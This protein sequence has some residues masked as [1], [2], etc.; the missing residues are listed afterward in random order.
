M[1]GVMRVLSVVFVIASTSAFAEDPLPTAKDLALRLRGY[2]SSIK[3]LRVRYRTRQL[4][5]KWITE[6]GVDTVVPGGP[7]REFLWLKDGR[8][9]FLGEFAGEGATPD[10]VRFIA[11]YDGKDGYRAVYFQTDAS[12]LR[13][14]IVEEG[15]PSSLSTPFARLLGWEFPIVTTTLLDLLGSKGS[16]P[17]SWKEVDG[18]ECVLVQLGTIAEGLSSPHRVEACFDPDVGWLPRRIWI[19]PMSMHE[20]IE[21]GRPPPSPTPPFILLSSRN[22]RFVTGVDALSGRRLFFPGGGSAVGTDPQSPEPVLEVVQVE[23]NPKLSRDQFEPE[24]P[25]GV[26]IVRQMNT[27]R[28]T[29]EVVGGAAGATL[30]QERVAED[31]QARG[32]VA[33]P[34][35]DRPHA[36]AEGASKVT[37][38]PDG[39]TAWPTL[40]LLLS[41]VTCALGCWIK[42][43]G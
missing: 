1:A 11:S 33:K 5:K 25:A 9:E 24:I 37:A 36:S 34:P 30:F 2:Q 29:R 7:W 14:V 16:K 15:R 41:A 39:R 38:R 13:S 18:H 26:Q 23:F 19:L 22:D 21:A 31:E 43:R 27:P 6:E 20:A 12:V 40:L 32:F 3:S 10:D 4:P 17:M 35:S 42:W 28:E 8:K